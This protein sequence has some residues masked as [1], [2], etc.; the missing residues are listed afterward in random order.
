MQSYPPGARIAGRYEVASRPLI[1]GMG[2]VY[3]CFDHQEQRPVALKTFR[4]EYLPDRSARDCFLR[5]GTKW[6]ELGAHPHIVRCHQVFKTEISDEVYLVL[7]LVVKEPGRDDAS[8]RA[9]L[10]PG[11]PL[12]VEHALLFALQVVRGMRH[13]AE[14]IRGFTH[15]DLKPENLLVGADR[16]SQVSVNR[17]R[18]TDFGIART[19]SESPYID[20]LSPP[21]RSH[22]MRSREFAGTP[23]Y[24]APEQFDGGE[25]DWRADVYALGCILVETLTGWMPVHATSSE[26]TERLRQCAQQHG[27][28]QVLKAARK[29]AD[30]FHPLL[31][32][33]LAVDSACRYGSWAEVESALTFTYVAI[34]GRA[35]PAPEMSQPLVRAERV[36]AGWS[37]SALGSSYMGLGKAM[38]AI[39]YF[40]RAQAA[41]RAEGDR[42]LE[43][44]GLGNLGGAC[45]SLGDTRRAIDYYE[46]AR[47]I[48]HEIGD[49]LNEGKAVASLGLAYINLGNARR[50]IGYFEQ[51]LAISREIGNRHEEG[52]IL[53]TLGLAY[54]DLGDTRRAI[55]YFEYALAIARETGDRRGE[56]NDLGNLGST[57]LRL[58][59]P[60]RAI[61]CY[62]KS[63]A[64]AREI[65]DRRG[66]EGILGNLGNVCFEQDDAR[67]ASGYFEQ[68]LAIARE[69]GDREG[70][71]K[72]LFGL[73]IAYGS[74]GRPRQ[75]SNYMK[76]ALDIQ[77]AIGDRLGEG[78]TLATLGSTHGQLGEFQD[79]IRYLEQALTIAR[80][81]ADRRGEAFSLANLGAVHAE[82]RDLRRA[83]EYWTQAL[84]IYVDIG[85]PTATRIRAY[86]QQIGAP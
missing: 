40:E 30:T 53:G 54:V 67:Q 39:P 46:Q 68:A 43:A 41:G 57:Y 79:A 13:A 58:G 51:A 64:I 60:R 7:E 5:E 56:G 37:L 11:V 26:S 20:Q 19:I 9:W 75:G 8:L 77:Q 32:K 63:L 78:Q 72:S 74:L 42:E 69:I 45:L 44:A 3:L 31:E 1:G 33:C 49:R 29:L 86:L 21:G 55:G 48:Q 80:E 24:A 61:E 71:A 14:T 35:I 62:Q 47:S 34:N 38:D 4:P 84:A 76:Q 16:L 66:E 36:A 85:D 70:E 65:A 25:L 2:I 83:R 22:S 18:I 73:G 28:G 15:L 27:E 17:L 52:S 12:M 10:V 59:N 6:V 50:A 23:E 82:L 81:I